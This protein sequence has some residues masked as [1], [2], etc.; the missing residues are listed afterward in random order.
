VAIIRL[1]PELTTIVSEEG[2]CPLEDGLPQ[3][4]HSKTARKSST[5]D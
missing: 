1:A 3:G 2:E 5:R 4:L